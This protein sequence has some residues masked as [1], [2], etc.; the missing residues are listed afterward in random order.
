MSDRFFQATVLLTVLFLTGCSSQIAVKKPNFAL[1]KYIVRPGDTIESVAY[2]Y[3]LHPDDL[4]ARNNLNGGS[5]LVPGSLLV[6][7]GAAPTREESKT[8]SLSSAQ[9]NTVTVPAPAVNRPL[10]KHVETVVMPASVRYADETEEIIETVEFEP[11][12]PAMAPIK[13]AIKKSAAA[14]NGWIWPAS[15]TVARGFQPNVVNRQGLDIAGRRGEAV[16]AAAD[17]TVV[18]SGQDLASHGK[19]VILRHKDNV[20]SAYS[21]AKELYVQEDEVV[22]AGDAIAGLADTDAESAILHFEIRK[23]GKPVNPLNYLPKR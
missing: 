9:R 16:V 20:L 23:D 6:I 2:R 12:T 5:S 18:Y 15:G 19:L 4:R 13:P 8:A 3:D 22:Q 1:G 17:G 21:F 10:K 11:Q 7:R 14:K